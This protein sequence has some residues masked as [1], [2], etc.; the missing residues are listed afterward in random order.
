VGIAPTVGYAERFG[1]GLVP[2]VPS[3]ALGSGE[4]TLMSMAAGYSAFANEGMLPTPTLIRRVETADGEVLFSGGSP[5]TRVVSEATAFLMSNMLADVVTSGTAAGV[6]RVGFTSQAA[7]KTG[8]T[9][10]YHDAWF[11]GYTPKLVTGV[12]VGYDMPR[13]IIANGYAAQLAVPIWG[14]F[15]KAA[16]GSEKTP[17][18]KSPPT[19]ATATI[20]RLSGKLA[21]QSCR[22]VARVDSDGY[23]S[24]ESMAYTEFFVRGTEPTTY[25]NYHDEYESTGWR[26]ASAIGDDEPRSTVPTSGREPRAA[27]PPDGDPPRPV[28]TGGSA[29]QPPAAVPGGSASPELSGASAPAEQPPA[30]T[31]TQRRGFWSRIFRRGQE[32][33]EQPATTP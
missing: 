11:V 27:V 26:V 10:D 4:V 15:M 6:R 18:F 2:H 21:G 31:P 14:R 29:A 17:W 24:I 3:L 7:G 33:V 16:T 5:Q 13:T 25:C 32:P 12:W 20:C 23:T 8:T 30:A 9:N 19:V 1:V 22:Y 28:S